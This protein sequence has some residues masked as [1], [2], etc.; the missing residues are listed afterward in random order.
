VQEEEEEEEDANKVTG[1]HEPRA[2]RCMT[3]NHSSTVHC[4]RNLKKQK[5]DA[6]APQLLT[7]QTPPPPARG[8]AKVRAAGDACHSKL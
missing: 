1:A 3:S 5:R 2:R 8:K 4:P 6:L 7:T